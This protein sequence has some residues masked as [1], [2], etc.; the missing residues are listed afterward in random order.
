[1]KF[2][3]TH[4]DT[5]AIFLW[6]IFMILKLPIKK[7]KLNLSFERKRMKD[8]RRQIVACSSKGQSNAADKGQEQSWK[9]GQ[10]VRKE[11]TKRLDKVNRVERRQ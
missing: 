4:L 6:P 8:K 7:K 5:G 3:R 9:P 10:R 2:P 1:M 11:G